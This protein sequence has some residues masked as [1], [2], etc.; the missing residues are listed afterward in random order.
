MK[1]EMLQ[2]IGNLIYTSRLIF[3]SIFLFQLADST[4]ERYVMNILTLCVL[5]IYIYMV[6]MCIRFREIRVSFTFHG[7][8]KGE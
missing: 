6:T 7:I 2:L 8:S 4:V 3:L 1:G 5:Y